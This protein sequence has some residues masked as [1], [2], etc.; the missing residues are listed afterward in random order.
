VPC[1]PQDNYQT[2]AYAVQ[3]LLKYLPRRWTVWE[4]AAG[5]GNVAA[6]LEAAGHKV[7]STDIQQTGR[8]F[9]RWKPRQHFD[10]IVTNPPYARMTAFLERCYELGKPFALLLPLFALGGQERHRLYRE[11]GVQLLVF[12]RRV[13]FEPEDEQVQLDGVPFSSAWFCW[14]LLKREIVF[15]ELPCSHD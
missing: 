3:P 13:S 1:S 5:R 11:R 7:I 8:D 15:E 14:K 12:D 2:P 6:T 9:L 4:C 10:C